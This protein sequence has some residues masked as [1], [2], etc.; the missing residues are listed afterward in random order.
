MTITNVSLSS[1]LRL[2]RISVSFINNR[3]SI[4]FLIEELNSRIKFFKYQVAQK[5]HAKFMPEIEFHYDDS[6][7]RAEKITKL[8]KNIND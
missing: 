1:D 2:A 8:M 4:N 7:K 5:W 3:R 6:L